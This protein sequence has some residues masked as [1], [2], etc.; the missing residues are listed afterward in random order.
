M[1]K[2]ITTLSCFLIFLLAGFSQN[3]CLDFDGINDHIEVP[4]SSSMTITE[5]ITMEVWVKQNSSSGLQIIFNKEG[6]YEIGLHNGEFVFAIANNWVFKYTGYNVS[7]NIWTHLAV[8]YNGSEYVAY[9]NGSEVY[10]ELSTGLISDVV[11]TQN[12]FW[13]GWRQAQLNNHFSG[14][15]DEIRIWN[16]ALTSAQVS[17]LYDDE[18][19]DSST[20]S[21]CL[22]A[23]YQFN[24][25]AGI[26]LSDLTG[27]GNTGTLINMTNSDWVTSNAGISSVSAPTCASLSMANVELSLI[28]QSDPSCFNETNGTITVQAAGGLVPYIYTL[29]GSSANSDGVFSMV[30]S[31][32]YT[33]SVSDNNGISDEIEVTIGEPDALILTEI[34]VTNNTCTNGTEGII[35][36]EASGGTMPYVYTLNSTLPQ[37]SGLYTGLP[38]GTY[39]LAVEDEFGCTQMITSEISSPSQI[40]LSI[41]N[42][43]NVSCNSAEDGS[44]V[45]FAEGGTGS[46]TFSLDGS[47]FQD[48][49]EFTGINA[50]LHSVTAMDEFGCIENI[51]FNITEP[52]IV[53]IEITASTNITCNGQADGSITASATGGIGNFQ[54]SIGGGIFQSDGI[55]TGLSAGTYTVIAQ[56]ENGCFDTT[57]LEITQPGALFLD[58][59]SQTDN[60]C[61]ETTSGEV[62]LVLTGTTGAVVYTLG[63]TT[64]TTGIFTGLAAGMLS[65]SATDENGCTESTSVNIGQ[66]SS[67]E[68]TIENVTD[69][70]C[71]GNSTGAITV[72]AS[73]GVE[74]YTYAIDGVDFGISNTFTGLFSGVYTISATDSE[75]CLSLVSVSISEPIALT[76]TVE[77]IVNP[78]CEGASNGSITFSISGG[79]LPYI[80]NDMTIN[81]DNLSMTISDLSASEID[82]I[83]TDAN[84]CITSYNISLTD[85]EPIVLTIDETVSA[86]C[87]TGTSGT[88]AVSAVGGDGNFSYQLGD[89]ISATGVF[90]DLEPGMVTINAIDGNGCEASISI[91]IIQIGGISINNF[92]ITDVACN[93]DQSG[94]LGNIVASGGSGTYMYSLDGDVNSIGVFAPLFAGN[95][96]LNVADENG[97]QG[98]V[99]VIVNQPDVISFNTILSD[100]SCNGLSDG[101]LVIDETSGGTGNI[102]Y[103]LNGETTNNGTF[104]GLSSGNFI[105]N[106]T[107][108]NNCSISEELTINEPDVL[109]ISVTSFTNDDGS[110]MNGDITV[111]ATGGT[112]PYIYSI[113]NKTSFQI[114]DIF[115]ELENIPYTVIVQDANGCEAE[116]VHVLTS[117]F[118]INL[119]KRFKLYPNPAFDL[120]T[121]ESEL[122]EPTNYTLI[123]TK[124]QQLKS[125][126][127]KNS[128]TAISVSEIPYGIYFFKIVTDKGSIYLKFLKAY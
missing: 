34:Q 100:V 48:S 128:H 61:G 21:Q 18:F 40:Q 14:S 49:N 65:V 113:D 6:E 92:E 86:N 4:S 120:I 13:I 109:S 74:P 111:K 2:S 27:N 41:I 9:V 17:S 73:N 67:I 64:N 55:F 24:E 105:L 69:V 116:V 96:T 99:E 33:V 52:D 114:D 88:I 93:G 102:S 101:Y 122:L 5:Q 117:S 63:G 25:N 98:S 106:I 62:T 72:S 39:I 60:S 83:V 57:I 78:T 81:E 45:I 95:Y 15:I 91:E 47:D 58:I 46:F 77:S 12:D 30:A 107:D 16:I 50:G 66:N 70:N 32:I 68:L 89:I 104:N 29:N 90:P 3:T 82:L 108:E 42:L 56:D 23:N 51:S 110:M 54:Y 43:T 44:V 125:G 84:S 28:S 127:I 19:L 38:M 11:P 118:D 59:V 112:E 22:M 75:G 7:S 36:V 20:P 115:T 85:P 26:S 35:E 119:V 71:Y 103:T 80:Y 8:T 79:T 1:K 10:S 94:S 37:A 31:G 87:N 124:G 123:N 126:V 76:V 53:E 121:L 97:C